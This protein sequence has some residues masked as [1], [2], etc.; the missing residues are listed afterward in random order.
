M[1]GQVLDAGRHALPAGTGQHLHGART[2]QLD[3]VG[4]RHLVMAV[5]VVLLAVVV[6]KI[7]VVAG[8]LGRDAAG[9][10]VDEHHLEEVE[11]GVV[12]VG[13][14]GLVHVAGPLGERRLEV[15]IRS[16]AGPV[17]FG[18]GAENAEEAC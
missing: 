17:L 7:G 8:L 2:G 11:P 13:T 14:D 5:G 18:G 12:E 3:R 10:V 9:G 1:E 16:D 6:L 4:L 15:R